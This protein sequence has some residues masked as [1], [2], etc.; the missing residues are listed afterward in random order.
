MSVS[1][2]AVENSL[3]AIATSTRQAARTLASLSTQQKN[4][5]IEAIA[6][7]LEAAAADITS[8]Q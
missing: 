8:R 4:E 2:A 1:S 5:A 7:A 6:Q 3:V